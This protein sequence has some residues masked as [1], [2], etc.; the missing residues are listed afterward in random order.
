MC[1]N[2]YET[3]VTVGH[4]LHASELHRKTG[5]LEPLFEVMRVWEISSGDDNLQ[6]LIGELFLQMLLDGAEDPILIREVL[7]F[8]GT[9]LCICDPATQ[10]RVASMYL[11]ENYLLSVQWEAA[12]ALERVSLASLGAGDDVV[13]DWKRRVKRLGDCYPT[14][15][16]LQA[17]VARAA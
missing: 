1:D 13:P 10:W 2:T 14:F 3:E 9:R 16:D 11:T 4:F 6:R 5:Q 17:L 12:Q 15:P 7:G 8:V